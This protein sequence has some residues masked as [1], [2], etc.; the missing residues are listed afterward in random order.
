MKYGFYFISKFRFRVLYNISYG[1]KGL[2]DILI[3]LL[4]FLGNILFILRIKIDYRF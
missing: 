1:F 3:F 2:S 4:I